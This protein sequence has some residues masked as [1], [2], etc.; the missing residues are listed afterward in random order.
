MKKISLLMILLLQCLLVSAQQVQIDRSRGVVYVP[1]T[2]QAQPVAD[3]Q[4]ATAATPTAHP[5]R[6]LANTERAVGYCE[7]DSI[8][9]GGAYFGTAGSYDMAA[10]VTSGTMA[11]YKGCKIVG[12]RFALSKTIGKSKIFIYKVDSEGNAEEV[13][14]NTV[15][16]TAA[17]WNEARLNSAQ[18]IEITGDDQYIMGF[19]YNESAAMVT[20]EEGALC[21]YGDK[22]SS[23]YSSL[24][25]QDDTFYPLSGVSD[26]CV[27]LIVDVSSLPR[28]AV[29]L[30]SV[31]NGT[32]YKKLG[33]KMD[34]MMSYSNSGLDAVNSV[35]FGFKVDEGTPQ[36]F[37][38][39]LATPLEPGKSATFA[40]VLDMPAD[41]TVGR[42][43]LNIFV[44]KI[45]GNDPVATDR[46]KLAD[47]F[48]AYNESFKHQKQYVEQYNS[49]N[50]VIAPYV[51]DYY[52]Q[53]AND[54]DVFAVNLYPEGQPLSVAS[55]TYLGNLYAYTYP[56]FTVN[57]FYFGMGELHYAFDINDY[58]VQ[59]PTL[60]YD[61]FRSIVNE[62]NGFPAF[63]TV[64][65]N[66]TY[67]ENTRQVGV[68]VSGDLAA[69]APAIFG[70]MALTVM[71]TEDNVKSSQNTYNTVSQTTQ[72]D[73]NYIHDAVLRA[74]LTDPLGDKIQ[75]NGNHYTAHYTYTLPAAYN[76]KNITVGAIVTKAFDEV[77]K[78]N[79]QMAD[80][81]NCNS[82]KL[83]LAT[84]IQGVTTDAVSAEG[85]AD[86]IY[87][88]SGMRVDSQRAQ[89]GI[90]I[91]R[92]NGKSV[93]VVR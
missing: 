80:I 65:I 91:I 76:S 4:S 9:Y 66:T 22:A 32:S 75:V 2:L 39:N 35:R 74:Y 16:R 15:R 53:L 87:T 34:L 40:K 79:M 47:P 77:N 21:F 44:D 82:V 49:Q 60:V 31:L 5:R 45:E 86:G 84:G 78:G 54:S 63:A 43:N 14:N 1:A 57:R 33:S 13:V 90:F 38:V 64:N 73:N 52:A 92:H 36:Y 6:A 59:F 58:A 81:T 69:D 20:A 56:C 50:S 29:N 41:V 27:Q 48:V 55:S 10:M 7:G 72:V 12:V 88:L 85:A 28:K 23:S 83:G 62:A 70:D 68:D 26:L 24:V 37:D 25:L 42:H 8:T 18:E 89:K 17:G 11:N 51:N 61:G 67:N 19:T 93:K 3:A 30:N 71:L 46:G